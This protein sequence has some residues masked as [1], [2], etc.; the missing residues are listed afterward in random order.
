M[1]SFTLIVASAL[2][3]G[4]MAASMLLLYRASSRRP[5]LLDWSLGGLFF[6]ASNVLTACA[7]KYALAY[8]LC[9]WAVAYAMD[10]KSVYV[11]F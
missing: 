2:V 9:C 8:M 3:A 6:L 4:T 11:K 7:G 1:D 5:C 10:R